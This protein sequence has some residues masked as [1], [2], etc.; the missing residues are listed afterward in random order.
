[1]G[2]QMAWKTWTVWF[3]HFAETVGGKLAVNLIANVDYTKLAC[4]VVISHGSLSSISYVSAMSLADLL[5]GLLGANNLP[6]LPPTRYA[7]NNVQQNGIFPN[8]KMSCAPQ[9]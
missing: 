6:S 4:C 7:N 2:L 3:V 1:M 5:D 8:S 9:T